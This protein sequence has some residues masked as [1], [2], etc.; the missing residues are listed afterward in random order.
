MKILVTGGKGQLGLSIKKISA[1]YP[2]MDFCFTDTVEL[3]ITNPDKLEKFITVNDF[4]HII[5]CAAYNEVDKAETEEEQARLINFTGVKHLAEI[6]HKHK[7]NFIHI[8]TDYVFDGKNYR[9]Y[10]EIDP[11]NPVN[12]YG[13]TKFEGEQAAMN[14]CKNTIIIRTSW[15]F[16]EFGKNFLKTILRISSERSQIKVVSDQIGTPTYAGD[17]AQAIL[18]IIQQKRPVREPQIYHYSGEGVASWYDFAHD[19]ISLTGNGC[20]ILP[21]STEEYPLPAARPFYS[22]LSKSKIK[23]EF[24]LSI[25]YWKISLQKSLDRLQKITN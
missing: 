14:H 21:V 3:D 12:F 15:L 11:P 1:D 2:G 5:N 24:G 6:S 18:I 7:L 25:P 17:L 9:P 8:S 16:S 20:E 22:V 13:L 23:H 19:I 10:T 4:T